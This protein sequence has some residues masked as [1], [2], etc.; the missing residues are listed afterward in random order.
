MFTLRPCR[1][2]QSGI[3][4]ALPVLAA[5]VGFASADDTAQTSP[6]TSFEQR[7]AD[8]E[9]TVRQ[10]KAASPDAAS[11]HT[12]GAFVEPSSP[13]FAP[14]SPAGA[15]RG[16]NLERQRLG[17]DPGASPSRG[18]PAGEVAGGGNGLSLQSPCR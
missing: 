7:I 5:L 6:P 18:L 4:W 2:R 12:G 9:E 8:L 1:R 3:R 13:A 17:E 15:G 11:P 14:D 16:I 10:L